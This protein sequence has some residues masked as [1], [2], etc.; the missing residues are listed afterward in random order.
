MFLH[1]TSA[2]YVDDYKIEVEFNDGKKGV[3]DL[4]GAL[5]GPAF[6]P[7]KDKSIFS[8]VRVDQELET[9]VWE[10]GTD[11]APEF[12]YFQTFK[13]DPALQATFKQWGYVE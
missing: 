5:H 3:A 10:N 6:E 11:L 2:E 9:I 7:L 8:N 12:V 13:D 4:S 1:I